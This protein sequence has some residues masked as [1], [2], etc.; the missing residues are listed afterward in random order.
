MKRGLPSISVPSTS[1]LS[2]A[3]RAA[4]MAAMADSK[5][6][7]VEGMVAGMAASAAAVLW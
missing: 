7:A 3:L 1:E 2:M 5:P 4:C 6:S